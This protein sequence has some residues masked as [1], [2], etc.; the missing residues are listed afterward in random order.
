[1]CTHVHPH[2]RIR[3]H[4]LIHITSVHR[5]GFFGEVFLAEWRVQKVVVKRLKTDVRGKGAEAER[6]NFIRE[7]RI[8]VTLRHPRICQF[9]GAST[10][11]NRYIALH[12]VEK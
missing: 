10:D 8:L 6:V 4:I 9:L 11:P 2:A 3:T 12:Y 1:V 7:L 5:E